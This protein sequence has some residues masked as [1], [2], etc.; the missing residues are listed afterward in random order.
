MFKELRTA[1]MPHREL[2]A[3]ATELLGLVAEEM[4]AERLESDD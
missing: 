1:G 2:V 4:K 3:L